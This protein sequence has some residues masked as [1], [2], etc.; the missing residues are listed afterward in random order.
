MDLKNWVSTL[1]F[2]PKKPGARNF[3]IDYTEK[4]FRALNL[5]SRV[6]SV[7]PEYFICI[8]VSFR[9]RQLPDENKIH[10]KYSRQAREATAVSGCTKT[11]R[12]RKVGNPEHTKT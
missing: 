4:I 7:N 8:V 3:E 10:T 6:H 9:T 11:P 5:A 1:Y 2:T 12:V